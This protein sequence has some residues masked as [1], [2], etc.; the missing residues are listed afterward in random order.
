LQ[1]SILT[2]VL[3]P[4]ALGIIMFGLGLS[5]TPADFKRVIVYPK[6]VLIGL[7]CQTLLMPAA[8]F[9][10]AKFCQLPAELAV[11][12]VL[13]SATPGGPTA[14]IYSHLA[15]GD[16]ALNI[17]LAAVNS[18]LSLFTLPL[19]VNLALEIFVGEAKAIPLQ[20]DKVLQ[21]F[22]IVLVPVAL[23]MAIRIRAAALAG[24]MSRP[25][26][27]LSA[28]LLV[29]VVIAAVL[30][31]REQVAER[32]A[33]VGAA[34]L[35]FNVLSLA[36]GYLIPRAARLPKKQAIAIGMEVGIHNGTLA[37]AIASSPRLLDNPTMAV[38]AAV[39]SLLA[40][41]TAGAFGAFVSRSGAR[42]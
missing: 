17:T 1:S 22:A 28:L 8:C 14:N 42:S 34:A 2:A 7:G 15:Q 9:A 24:A 36:V 39:Y 21:V 16:V 5:L 37:I 30:R 11:G 41:F 23:G 6:A 33:Q 29:L 18:L 25:V 3:L 13:L 26:R 31:E 10:V 38:P 35:L 20:L 12:L 4:L 32:I 19:I 27:W 40:F